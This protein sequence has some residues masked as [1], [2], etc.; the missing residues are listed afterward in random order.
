[1]LL[2]NGPIDS[3]KTDLK[4]AADT[5]RVRILNQ[6]AE[7][8]ELSNLDSSYHY[9]LMASKLAEDLKFEKG[10]ANSYF[11]I[12]NYFHQTDKYQEALDYFDKAIISYQN[13]QYK[14]GLI[15]AYLNK[16]KVLRS[17]GDFDISLYYY[18]ES[19]KVSEEIEDKKGVAWALLNIG[20]IHAIR[21]DTEEEEGLPYFIRALEI[22]KEID[23]KRCMAYASN[24]IGNVYAGLEKYDL[25]LKYFTES[26]SLRKE[27]GDKHSIATAMNSLSDVYTMQGNNDSAL[28]IS[29]RALAINQEEGY[30]RGLVHSLI[31]IGNIYDEINNF[32][33]AESYF[34]QG[35]K[36]A[37]KIKAKRLIM[38]AYKVLYLMYQKSKNYE[39]A[40]NYYKKSNDLKDT[41]FSENSNA[42]ILELQTQYET[43]KKEAE[44]AILNDEKIIQDLKLKE[45]ENLK[46]FLFLGALLTLI[47]AITTYNSYRHKKKVNLLLK[48][49]NKMELESRLK[50]INLFGQQVSKEIAEELL[51]DSF[52]SA[53]KQLYACIMFLDIRGFTPFVGNLTPSEIIQYQND[54]FGFMIKIIRKNHG[55][56][57]QFLGDGFMAT[58]GAPV[59]SG[60]DCQNAVNASMQIVKTLRK[61]NKTGKI[62][63]TRIGIGL[64]AGNIVTGNVGTALRKQYS[65]TGIP[66]I[67]ASRIEQLNK[68]FNS[69]LLI[70]EEVLQ[71]VDQKKLTVESLGPKQVKG[72]QEPIIIYKLA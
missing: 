5:N 6:L 66:V 34:K 12:G 55:I 45:S 23:D 41:I 28:A 20:I 48:E 47:L 57:N 32:E 25:A 38:S 18:L 24:N 46:R 65:I 56:I 8:Y 62:H 72:R 63:E 26:L 40:L 7:K 31:D 42:Q 67:L 53:G 27:I 17:L 33:E 54:V 60:N 4:N 64:Y 22:A 1:M 68:E 39:L 44:I 35:L 50:A 15:I 21:R 51:S 58:F 3:L 29:F 61:K 36:I 30:Q 10:L 69:Q 49:K 52:D 14:P 37:Q 2:A 59:S 71:H 9:A 16:G 43:E 13:I 19:L 11:N 70:S